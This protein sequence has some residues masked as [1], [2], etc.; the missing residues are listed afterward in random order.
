[1]KVYMVSTGSYSDWTVRGLFSTLEIAQKCAAMLGDD[2]GV[3]EWEIDALTDRVRRGVSV[4]IVWSKTGGGVDVER[5]HDVGVECT[6][7]VGVVDWFPDN[8]DRMRV[9][10]EATD[11]AHA[12]KIA[13]DKFRESVAM[14]GAR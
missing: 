12:I 11:V 10:V 8:G 13:A 1:M 6:E 3:E 9:Y 2:S 5:A 7:S 4:W 14:R